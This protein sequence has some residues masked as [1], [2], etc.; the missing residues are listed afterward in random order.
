MGNRRRVNFLRKRNKFLLLAD[1]TLVPIHR[2]PSFTMPKPKNKKKGFIDKKN[3]VSFHLVHRSQQV[4]M[5]NFGYRL[6]FNELSIMRIHWRRT[7]M[8][9]RWCCSPC[10]RSRKRSA[11]SGSSS[12]TST[13][14]S[15]TSRTAVR[16]SMTGARRTGESSCRDA[17]LSYCLVSYYNDTNP[18]SGSS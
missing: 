6:V 1:S 4:E 9:T 10:P 18:G 16:W 17:T 11:S 5:M 7:A 3:A 2:F 12:R 14:T 8:L 15:S 13:T